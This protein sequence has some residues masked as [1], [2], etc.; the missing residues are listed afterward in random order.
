ME[1]K[2]VIDSDTK[3][4]LRDK[5]LLLDTNALLDAYRLPS[6]FYDLVQEFKVLGCD[7][8]TTK[9]IAIE[10]LGG[11]KDQADIDKKK[12]FL[13]V[14]FGKPLGSI[15]LPLD[16]EEPD[17]NSLL[18]FSRQ[19]KNFSI[20]DYELYCTLKKYGARIALMTR[21]H[22]DFSNKLAKR[23]SFIT[24]LGNAEIHTHSIC[25]ITSP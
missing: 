22:K 10:F 15:Y 1:T 18:A 23:I 20:A 25:N 19:A 17:L 7:L 21:N 11:T 3:E 14:I 6:E 8:A 24:L 16:H 12:E 5:T 4:A 2:F 9:S 13:E